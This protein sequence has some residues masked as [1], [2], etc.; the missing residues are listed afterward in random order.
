MT[1][2]RQDERE[3]VARKCIR[4]TEEV[5]NRVCHIDDETHAALV[6]NIT[7]L[8]KASEAAVLEEAATFVDEYDVSEAASQDYEMGVANTCTGIAWCLRMKAKERQS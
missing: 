2:P 5:W 8:L 1:D 4:D 3:R 7:N 6:R